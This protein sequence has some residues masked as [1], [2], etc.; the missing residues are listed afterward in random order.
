MNNFRYNT[1][2][3]VLVSSVFLTT[4]LVSSAISLAHADNIEVGGGQKNN[5]QSAISSPGAITPD[6]PQDKGRSQYD[7]DIEHYDNLIRQ[8]PNDATLYLDKVDYLIL[9][10]RRDE[11]ISTLTDALSKT[12]LEATEDELIKIYVT[13][14]N[15]HKDLNEK[16]FY[17]RKTLELT[18]NNTALKR[19]IQYLE[20]KIKN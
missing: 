17:Y 9:K 1:I 15:K 7:I 13:L 6:H 14:G 3:R 16:L 18:P 4:Y 19:N 5:K 11:I 10:S 8:N 2:I 12:K 20:N